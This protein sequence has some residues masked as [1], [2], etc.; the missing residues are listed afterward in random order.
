MLFPDY[1][2]AIE[3]D[4]HVLISSD[5][6]LLRHCSY[7]SSVDSNNTGSV[8]SMF[9][10]VKKDV[11]GYYN[12]QQEFTKKGHHKNLQKTKFQYT[13]PNHKLYPTKFIHRPATVIIV[14]EKVVHI[15]FQGKLKGDDELFEVSI[16]HVCRK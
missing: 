1:G 15:Q 6:S 4:Q 12:V 10:S 5:G 2:I 9:A 7:P 8:Y 11:N 16:D 13:D 14:V 3:I